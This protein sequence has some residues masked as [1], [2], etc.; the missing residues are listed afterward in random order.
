M[1]A[2]ATVLILSLLTL[3]A[4]ASLQVFPTDFN[5]RAA[6]GYAS[7]AVSHDMAATLLD[8]R[9]IGSKDSANIDKQLEVAREGIDIA[10]TLTGSIAEDRLALALASLDAAKVY[11]CGKQPTNP[12]CIKR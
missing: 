4:C 12:N 11:L 6:A 9:V 10:K 3:G 7:I 2:V 8:G 1:K 5:G